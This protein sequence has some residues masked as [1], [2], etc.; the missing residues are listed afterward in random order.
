MK[1]RWT[2]NSLRLRIA[3]EELAQLQNG[4]IAAEEF[5]LPASLGWSV[6]ISISDETALQMTDGALS[7]FLSR[8][9]LELLGEAAREGVY[10]QRGATRFFIEKDFPCAHPRA[11]EAAETQTATFAPPPD[12]EARKTR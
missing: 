12:F 4:Q 6:Q 1:I 7:F 11:T 2:K 10:F 3:P 5:A 9:D 8:A